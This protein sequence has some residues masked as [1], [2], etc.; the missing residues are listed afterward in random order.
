M[1]TAGTNG[2]SEFKLLEMA[3]TFEP[4]PLLIENRNRFVLFPIQ[5]TPIWEMYKRAEASF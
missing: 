2:P 5:Y 1:Q 4:E 3:D